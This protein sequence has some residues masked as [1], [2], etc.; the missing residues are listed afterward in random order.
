MKNSTSTQHL[1]PQFVATPNHPL[2]QHLRST[3]PFINPTNAD[4]TGRKICHTPHRPNDF[5]DRPKLMDQIWKQYA[6][7]NPVNY[8][9]PTTRNRLYDMSSFVRIR[10]IETFLIPIVDRVDSFSTQL[11][12][13]T[14]RFVND[15]LYTLF[16]KTGNTTTAVSH[17]AAYKNQF[18]PMRKGITNMIK[19]QATGAV[20]LPTNIKLHI[21]ASSKDIIH[22]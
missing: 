1:P 16:T 4:V 15:A 20:A 18:R 6:P 7:N 12:V 10:L 14:T 21:I 11:P 2:I 3:Y 9:D 8:L 13:N 5:L 17:E 22:S 19:L